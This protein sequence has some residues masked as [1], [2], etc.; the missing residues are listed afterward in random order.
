MEDESEAIT[1]QRRNKTVL[2]AQPPRRH[3]M[4]GF[5]RALHLRRVFFVFPDIRHV[6]RTETP[7]V[8]HSSSQILPRAACLPIYRF[9][10]RFMRPKCVGFQISEA[11]SCFRE[12]RA[13]SSCQLA[14]M[15]APSIISTEHSG[16][17]IPPKTAPPSC[18]I[19][20]LNICHFHRL[21]M[22]KF[23]AFSNGV[24]T[25]DKARSRTVSSIRI[26][27]ANFSFGRRHQRFATVILCFVAVCL[28]VAQ[29]N[30]PETFALTPVSQGE[31][32]PVPIIHFQLPIKTRCR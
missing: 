32:L 18:L 3:R 10:T 13:N 31:P 15:H 26:L 27:S 29:R 14:Y 16:A 4:E 20:Q 22:S 6:T 9:P 25:N 23:K 2:E 28:C 1:K 19:S 7:A 21:K 24:S 12:P 17:P 11:L 8:Q 30:A 5:L